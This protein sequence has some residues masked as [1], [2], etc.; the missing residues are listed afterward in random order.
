MPNPTLRSTRHRRA[1][2]PP[3]E[4]A[5]LV[6]RAVAGDE[7]A[8]HDLVDEFGNLVWSIARSHRLCDADAAE[9]TQTTW[10][11]LVEHAGRLNDP[12]RVG[13]WL[14]TTAR[15]ECL[16]VLRHG[17]RLVPS[18]DVAH[19]QIADAP[20]HGAALMAEERD[21]ALWQAFE[22]LRPRDRALLRMLVADPRPS[23]EEIGA[24]LDMPIG[25]IGPTSARALKR[26]RHEAESLGVTADVLSD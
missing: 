15:R 3:S 9:V 17:T 5:S 12:A 4:V 6:K 2:R 21:A 8:W 10:T 16:R 24:A 20:E 14:A 26:L 18:G 22:A 23:Y 19:D 1:G 7:R 25:S 13:A 11:H